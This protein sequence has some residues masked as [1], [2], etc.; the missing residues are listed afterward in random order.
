MAMPFSRLFWL[1]NSAVVLS[2]FHMPAAAHQDHND[3]NDAHSLYE[4][5]SPVYHDQYIEQQGCQHCQPTRKHY[6]TLPPRR[7]PPAYVEKSYPN[8]DEG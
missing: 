8:L 7:H 4:Q 2:F 5:F 1:I 3:R 6:R